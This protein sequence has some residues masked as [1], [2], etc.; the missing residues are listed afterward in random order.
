V[1]CKVLVKGVAV[2]QG[3]GFSGAV[4]LLIDEGRIARMGKGLSDPSA[5]E[6]RAE[7][8]LALP[9]LVDLHAHLGE[10]GHE[11]RESLDTGLAA[12]AWGGFTH[13][14]A[15]P[16]TQPPVDTESAVQYLKERASR[17]RGARLLICAALTKE[18]SGM[19]L[20]E[21]AHLAAA[22]ACALGDAAPVEDPALMRRALQYAS[23]LE[24]PVFAQAADARLSGG[25][26]AH[27]G[28]AGHWLGLPG[29]PASAEWIAVARE[30]LLAEETGGRVHL[31]GVS[32]GRSVQLIR[33]AKR[34][35]VRVTA[36]VGFYHLL[37]D[38]E[39]LADYDTRKKLMPPLRPRADG[40]ALLE[41][42]LDGTV[43]CI[44][45]DHTP[46]TPE[47]KD[48]EFDVAPFG[49]AGLEVALPALYSRLVATGKVSWAA[50]IEAL[51]ARPRRIAGLGE[52]RIAE[53]APCD[54]TLFA[55]G[56]SGS[57]DPSRWRSKARNTPLA[58]ERLYGR[59]KGIA[60]GR[61]LCGPCFEE[62]EEVAG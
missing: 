11:E 55:P 6:I 8:W 44:V 50:L 39:A 41:G 26:V 37:L 3:D 58:G 53:G 23:M 40:E 20:A 32:T 33:E 59:V 34:R 52:A 15:M 2:W 60:V 45:T 10:P 7:D 29:I 30:L 61:R 54:L 42:V 21:L 46:C 22:G 28:S 25:G 62:L 17:I 31:Q 4:D 9:G 56:E 27:E 48:A 43:D 14:V 47:E 13:V 1:S 57:V 36:E 18:R 49:A 38:D 5:V 12:A 24:L 16:D 51:S 35:G 19:E